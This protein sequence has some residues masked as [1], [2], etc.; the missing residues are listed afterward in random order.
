MCTNSR[1]VFNYH[2]EYG[3]GVDVARPLT[4]DRVEIR[5]FAKYFYTNIVNINLL[6]AR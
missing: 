3:I 2:A 4:K 6:H 1:L 5:V